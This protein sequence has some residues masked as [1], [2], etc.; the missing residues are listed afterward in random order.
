MERRHQRRALA[1]GGDVAAAEIGDRR[2]C[3]S[4]RRSRS[5][6]RA[7]SVYGD[8]AARRVPQRLAVASRWRA[9]PSRSTPARASSGVR[10]GGERA[11]RARR[12]ARRTPSSGTGSRRCDSSSTR[13]RSA[14]RIRRALGGDDGR[15]GVEA[16]E[17]GVDRVGARARDQA[18]VE[19]RHAA[20]AQRAASERVR[21]SSRSSCASS[22]ATAV[23]KRASSPR[24]ERV[25]LRQLDRQRIAVHAGDAEFVVQVR[26]GREAG[27]ADVAD[28]L[29]LVD[30]VPA[31]SLPKRD[32]W[33]YSVEYL[34]ACSRMTVLP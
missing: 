2:R 19:L 5:D 30:L 27:H 18:E 4:P 6:R 17:R 11:R 10:R 13:G 22:G 31:P 20:A 14:A 16:H 21:P 28:R 1:A 12:R 34:F 33:P 29:A 26:R 32:R 9:R 23:R 7:C 15:R 8:R 24:H 3:R 25:G